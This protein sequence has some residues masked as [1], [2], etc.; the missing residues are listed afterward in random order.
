MRLEKLYAIL[1]PSIRGELPLLTIAE[2]LLEGGA[3]LIQYRN[4][5]ASSRQLLSDVR[6]LVQLAWAKKARIVV[7]DRAD[8]AWLGH[9]HGVHVGQLDLQV[10]HVRK[11]LGPRKMIGISTH[12]LDQAIEAAKTSATY[13]AVGPIFFTTSK[14]DPDPVVGLEGLREIRQYLKQPIV[15]IGGI[16][17]EN[18]ADVIAAGADSV[19]VISDLLRAE[20]ISEHTKRFVKMLGE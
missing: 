15:A 3:R 12:C 9:A 7:N 11:I 19:A 13:I 10:R 16:T 14:N 20:D 1:D 4:K 8:V 6:T 5:T 18:A 17:A 2:R